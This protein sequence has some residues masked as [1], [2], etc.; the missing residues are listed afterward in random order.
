MDYVM[1]IN[2]IRDYITTQHKLE[3]KIF[4]KNIERKDKRGKMF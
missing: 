2:L 3:P 4:R 1:E